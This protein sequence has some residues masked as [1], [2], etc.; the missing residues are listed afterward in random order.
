M[1]VLGCSE[2][3]VAA[4]TAGVALSGAGGTPRPAPLLLLRVETAISLIPSTSPHRVLTE[5]P[6]DHLNCTCFSPCL[7]PR[8]HRPGILGPCTHS[9]HP[10]L[11]GGHFDHLGRG[12]TGGRAPPAGT[13]LRCPFSAGVPLGEAATTE[14]LSHHQEK[15]EVAQTT[16]LALGR[17][18]AAAH[19]LP[20]PFTPATS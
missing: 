1:C 13:S 15:L 7:A 16:A 17:S 12:R 3:V 9:R 14:T 5:L 6:S 4:V 8:Q 19:A 20:L 10:F 18:P 11:V 2:P